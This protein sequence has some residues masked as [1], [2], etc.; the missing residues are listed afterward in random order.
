MVLAMTHEEIVTLAR[1][2]G[3]ALLPRP[4]ADPLPLPDQGARRAAPARRRAAHARVHHEGLL[5]V[6]PRRRGARRRATRSTS[7]PTTAIFD[8]VGLRVVPG[9]VRRRDDGR[10]SARTST[11]RPAR[12]ARTTS[13]SRPATRP[14]SRSRAPSRS[15]SSCPTGW[16]RPRRSTTPGLDTVADVA[17]QLGVPAGRAAEG[18]PGH[19]RRP[20]P[21]DGGGPRRPPRQRDQARATRSAPTFRPAHARRSSRSG[22]ARPATSARS[23]PTC[24]SCSTTR[25]R[26]ARYVTGANRDRPR[27]CAASS[28]A[29]TSRSSA[30]TCA[31]VEAGDT[32]DGSAIRIEPAIEIGNI[33]KLGTRYSEPLGAT[34]LDETGEAQP[35]W[36]GSYGI[37]PARIAA[38]AVEQF[39][40]EHGISWPRV[41]RAVGR[42]A[43]RPRQAGH[44]RSARSPR[45]STT[46]CARPASTCS[47][48]TATRARARSSP[49]PSCSAARCG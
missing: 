24:R 1:R 21:D 40:D 22:S 48:T 31:R 8:R 28:R 43:R 47:T 44:A 32:V 29:A 11:W 34:Y 37:G 13:R 18:V 35:I 23:A 4:A 49:T 46:S 15:R 3:R 6:R 10:R 25:S 9:G 26:P 41:D 16:P 12:P 17:G 14:T 19:R 5:H 36:M 33:F 30:P 2:P 20:R 38:A 45:R 39:A 27:T 7:G 42:R